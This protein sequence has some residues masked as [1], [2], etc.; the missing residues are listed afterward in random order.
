[1]SVIWTWLQTAMIATTIDTIAKQPRQ[2]LFDTILV[3]VAARCNLACSYCYFFFGEDQRWRS[4]PGQMSASVIKDLAR[5][6]TDLAARQV[7][8]FAIV[9]HGGEPLLL[10]ERKLRQTLGI[11]RQTLPCGRIPIS[12]QTNGAL[13]TDRLLDV[14]S[15]FRTTLSVSIDGPADVNDKFRLTQSGESSFD[16][17]VKGISLLR[18]HRDSEF[19]FSG[20]LTVINPAV[21]PKYVYDF[22]KGLGSPKLDF[23]YRDGNHDR[24]PIG[25]TNFFSTEYGDWLCSLWDYYMADRSPT[26]V[27]VLDDMAK[28]I[29]GAQNQ[30]EG[31][32]ISDFSI[33]IVDTDGSVAKNDTLKSSYEGADTFQHRWNVTTDSLAD[34]A[35]TDEYQDYLALQRPSSKICSSCDHLRVC[36]GGM[37]LYRWRK[38]ANY[39]NPSVY[40]YD[41]QK[42]ITHL[43]QTFRREIGL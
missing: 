8:G 42:I 14:C 23:L 10:G 9:L 39:D 17:T 28:L 41:H 1:M 40:C 6:L 13:I 43:K 19:L 29:L 34:I 38:G 27:R 37:S 31:V 24:L 7:K 35:E 36:G 33:A 12:I 11:L 20:T 18:D 30:K 25:K 5:N 3:K 22:L 21:D 32:G 26:P 16:K 15:E 2:R 4:Q